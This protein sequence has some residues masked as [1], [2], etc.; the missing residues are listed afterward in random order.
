MWF[1][2]R[3]NHDWKRMNKTVLPTTL[4]PREF[5]LIILFKWL[6]PY[7]HL[8]LVTFPE[9]IDVLKQL[10]NFVS[11]VSEEWGNAKL[12]FSLGQLV[13]YEN[14]LN[15][16]CPEHNW[17]LDN[18]KREKSSLCFF[19]TMFHEESMNSSIMK[20]MIL[21]ILETWKS[22]RDSRLRKPILI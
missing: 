18:G 14:G 2:T 10:N 15:R 4:Y 3:E 22:L 20:M 5:D 6:N 19:N 9:N 12:V 11:V 8:S 21:P 1:P 13:L 17:K 16:W 7:F